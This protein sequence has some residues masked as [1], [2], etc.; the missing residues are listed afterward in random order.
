MAEL[1][2]NRVRNEELGQDSIAV[3]LNIASQPIAEDTDEKIATNQDARGL[4]QWNKPR[5][6]IYRYLA[7]L[8]TFVVMGMNDAAYG[9][10]IF[11]SILAQAST[12]IL[13]RRLFHT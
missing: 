13:F 2:F 7:S 6:N 8:Y 12:Y 9:V 5:I 1:Q 3:S 4:E 10:S 11:S